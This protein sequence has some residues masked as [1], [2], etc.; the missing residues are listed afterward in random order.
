MDDFPRDVVELQHY[1]KPHQAGQQ[2]VATPGTGTNVPIWILGS[3]LF[4][5]QLAALLGLPFA[6]AS[7]FAPTYLD[8]R[9][10][11]IA[12]SSSLL[13]PLT[14]P[15][16][17]WVP[18]CIADTNEEATFLRSSALPSFVNLQRGQ[19][20]PLQ[21]CGRFE[22]SLN[23]GEQQ[24]MQDIGQVSAIGTKSTARNAVI[25]ILNRTKPMRLCLSQPFGITK[26]TGKLPARRSDAV[27][28]CASIGYRGSSRADY[29][30][31]PKT[32]EPEP[33]NE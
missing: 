27:H 18:I 14:L 19:P 4:G 20:G 10:G 24:M 9:S 29:G 23:P 33:V 3:S 30:L 21:A 28:R 17:W 12:K 15:M 1:L 25:E 32:A 13:K 31:G 26:A 5:A 8:T 6:F 11:S 16:S 22:S 7:H 2:V